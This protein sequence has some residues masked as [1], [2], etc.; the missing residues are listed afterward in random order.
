MYKRRQEDSRL[1]YDYV[2]PNIPDTASL[3]YGELTVM[4]WIVHESSRV[5]NW[6]GPA[7]VKGPDHTEFTPGGAV[8]WDRPT[9]FEIGT[10]AGCS[11]VQFSR[12]VPGADLHSLNILPED[13]EGKPL[14]GEIMAKDMIGWYARQ[15]GVKYTQHFGDS[16]K[17]DYSKL[18]MFDVA[19][20]DG[21]HEHDYIINDT[22]KLLPRLNP[23]AV[24]IWH[25]YHRENPVGVDTAN[26]IDE[27]DSRIFGGRLIHIEGTSLV[28]WINR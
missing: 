6:N 11:M 20:I 9:I 8:V 12:M 17:F 19:F 24:M 21:R 16:R 27:M 7:T 10:Y 3:G 22:K 1:K 26:T 25:D 14:Q 4:N 13:V 2:I 23:G 28:Y 15:S 18:P 5:R